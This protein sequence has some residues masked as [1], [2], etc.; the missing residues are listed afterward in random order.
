MHAMGNLKARR[1]SQNKTLLRPVAN[2][3]IFAS[4]G[5]FKHTQPTNSPSAKEKSLSANAVVD[6]NCLFWVGLSRQHIVGLAV[7]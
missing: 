7:A 3:R 4:Y 2:P 6:S 5:F 1:F